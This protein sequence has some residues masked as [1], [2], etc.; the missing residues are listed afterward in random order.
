MELPG[1]APTRHVK[2]EVQNLLGFTIAPLSKELADRYGLDMKG[3][4]L[5]VTEI[6]QS[7]NAFS[8]GLREGDLIR[9]VNQ[10]KVGMASDLNEL[11]RGAQKGSN[12]LLQIARRDRGFFIAFSL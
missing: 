12:V 1:E 8:S 5:V 3:T 11:L 6:D 9:T 4:G 2:E 10:G 7:S